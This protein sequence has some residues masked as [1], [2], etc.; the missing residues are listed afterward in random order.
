MTPR[1][2]NFIYISRSGC[3]LPFLIIFN[4][5]FGLIFFKPAIWLLIE[6]I[7]ILIFVLA[8]YLFFRKFT[9]TASTHKDGI[10]DVEGEIVEEKD[11]KKIT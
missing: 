4:A 7:L 3:L 1:Q 2:G 5:F 6:T 11:T 8:A 10:I 9:K